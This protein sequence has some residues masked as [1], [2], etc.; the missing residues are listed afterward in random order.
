VTVALGV[1]LGV[2]GALAGAVVGSFA[3]VVLSR[4]WGGAV[5]GRSRC[6]SCDRQLRWYELVPFASYAAQG[7]RCRTCRAPIGRTALVVET[8]G[9][10]LGAA[11]VLAVGLLITR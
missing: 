4:G 3:G 2:F 1:I 8:L 6:D 5:R 7:G 11:L 10:V 9:A